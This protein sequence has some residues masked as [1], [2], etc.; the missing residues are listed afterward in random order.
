LRVIKVFSAFTT[1]ITINVRLHNYASHAKEKYLTKELYKISLSLTTFNS[2][3]AFMVYEIN[4]A[5]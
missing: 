3:G 2:I 4:A 1:N 5:R